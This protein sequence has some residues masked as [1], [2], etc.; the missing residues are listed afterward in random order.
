MNADAELDDAGGCRGSGICDHAGGE[1]ALTNANADVGHG[2]GGRCAGGCDVG[3][4][5]DLLRQAA[6]LRKSKERFQQV[7]RLLRKLHGMRARLVGKARVRACRHSP[8]CGVNR[9]RRCAS[10]LSIHFF[11]HSSEAAAS[12]FGRR[13]TLNAFEN[14]SVRLLSLAVA[15]DLVPLVGTTH[16]LQPPVVDVRGYE[17]D[18]GSRIGR[19]QGKCLQAAVVGVCSGDMRR[20]AERWFAKACAN[21]DGSGLGGTLREARNFVSVC[22]FLCKE[23]RFVWIVEREEEFAPVSSRWQL[24]ASAGECVG[25]LVWRRWSRH[26][27]KVQVLSTFWDIHRV[28]P[29]SAGSAPWM[30]AP[31]GAPK[32]KTGFRGGDPRQAAKASVA[33]R[34]AAQLVVATSHV[35]AEVPDRQDGV[36]VGGG[37]GDVVMA[38]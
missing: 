17:V 6:E 1:H 27:V 5:E 13:C 7:R 29:G 24:G 37:E 23:K 4:G 14:V 3:G 36:G 25:S 19:W 11:G 22:D 10:T 34:Q 21:N 16:F 26:V 18:C 2:D 32:K 15:V 38:P 30:V 28:E 31:A 35:E 12:D 9:R 33:K 20:R 8:G